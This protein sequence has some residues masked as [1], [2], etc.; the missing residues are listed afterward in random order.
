MSEL[1]SCRVCRAKHLVEILN[2]G[3]QNLSD[4][5]S[6]RSTPQRFPLRLVFCDSCGLAQLDYSVER[7]LMYHNG[8]GYKSGVNELIVENLQEIVQL[9][10]NIRP[11]AQSWLDIASNDGTLL[12]KVGTE[13]RR[14][15]V[16]PV[17]KFEKE[18]SR[19][20]DAIISD[21]FSESV[22]GGEKFDVI[23]SI[24]M[25]YDLDN[26]VEF[27]RQV[28]A[29]LSPNGVW[30]IQQNYLGAMY[31][32]LSFDN[33][34]HEHLTYFSL[35]A[36]ER[37]LKEVGLQVTYVE[38]KSIN[39]GSILTVVERVGAK[40]DTSVQDLFDR[41]KRDKLDSPE[42][43]SDF[44]IGVNEV[45]AELKN[46]LEGAKDA[47]QTVMIYGAS[48]RG[49]VIWQALGNS[50]SSVI[51]A[52][53]RQPEKVG[54]FYSAVG[55]PII[56]ESEMRSLKPD[57]LLVGPWFLREVFLE[58]ESDYIAQGGTLVFPLPSVELIGLRSQS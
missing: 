43:A 56:S 57:M 40:V 37:V 27:A 24:S 5:R 6:D 22:V 39:G 58:R 1:E 28:E 32:N 8:Y 48:T 15:G 55:V 18:A 17:A 16:D 52:V 20:A 7:E 13:Y 10:K 31:Q 3:D 2:L 11:L 46:L 49:A 14:V 51:A 21:F 45:I 12:S 44:A 4:F 53:E 50:L 9:G 26:P 30:I 42:G 23:T 25:F 54:K 29:C 35:T 47:K 19:H 34:C 41:E 36:L 33:I 38:E